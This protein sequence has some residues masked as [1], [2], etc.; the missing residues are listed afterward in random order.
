MAPFAR[1]A[2]GA[3]MPVRAHT[4]TLE[5]QVPCSRP[6][7]S[8]SETHEEVVN[9]SQRLPPQ[10]GKHSHKP[11]PVHLNEEVPSKKRPHH[12]TKT[13]NDHTRVH[14]RTGRPTHTHSLSRTMKKEG[15]KTT[16]TSGN[17]RGINDTTRSVSAR[18]L[19]RDSNERK[20]SAGCNEDAN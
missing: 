14:A 12:D 3:R 18:T 2:V 19:A 10:P 6:P 7:Q 4:H 9:M 5:A 17:V 15:I 1:I 20:A 11:S 13:T 16:T 8:A